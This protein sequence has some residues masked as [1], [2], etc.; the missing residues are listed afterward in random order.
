MPQLLLIEDS[1]ELADVT[2][3]VLSK[4]H[5]VICAEDL[6][7]AKNILMKQ[8]FDLILLDIS[9]P[10][11]SGFTL[12]RWLR[13][14]LKNQ[15]PIIFLTGELELS[16]RLTGLG[17]GAV[18]YILKPFYGEELLARIDLHLKKVSA[19]SEV[20]VCE[21]LKFDWKQQRVSLIKDQSETSLNL[22]PNEYKILSF[23]SGQ[24]DKTMSRDE[25]ITAV[26]GEG[27]AMSEKVV[28][29]HVSNL[30]KKLIGTRCKIIAF[31]K[32]GYRL[33]ASSSV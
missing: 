26:W 23:L 10:D 33:S 30:R 1:V 25:I 2:Q 14:E 20:F 5:V 13:E 29:S 31:E 19:T 9:L 6:T 15:T 28:N 12:F 18:D 22:T 8:K 3:Q 21:D 17:L 4:K 24:L 11:G 16:S 32:I 27:Y 7:A